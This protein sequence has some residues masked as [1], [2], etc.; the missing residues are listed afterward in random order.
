MGLSIVTEADSAGD[1]E[2]LGAHLAKASP[3]SCVIYLNGDLGTGKTTLVRGFLRYL[4]HTG[5]VRSPTYTLLESYELPLRRCF[6]I[7]LYRLSDPDEMEYLGIRDLLKKD[8][9]VLIEWPA[10]G[11]GWLPPADVEIRIEYRE[12]GRILRFWSRSKKGELILKQYLQT[13]S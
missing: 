8:A 11:A 3:G 12:S 7:D 10:R 13:E 2:R 6:H 9:V 1:Q 4:G 5:P